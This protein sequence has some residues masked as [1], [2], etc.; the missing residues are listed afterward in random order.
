MEKLI[1]KVNLVGGGIVSILSAVLG[2]MWILFA[3]LYILNILDWITGWY[4][5]S[6]NKKS[7]SKVGAQ[8]IAKK[9][10]YWI[11]I[12][13]GFFI[14]YA[15][16]EMGRVIGIPLEFMKSIG[17]FVLANYIVN[18]MRSLLENLLKLGIPV[19]GFLIKGLRIT[20]DLIDNAAEGNLP[21]RKDKND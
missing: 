2:P 5:A 1:D 3:A 11:V 14:G 21:K 12:G 17:W 7:S 18:E 19:Q 8:G 16:K 10:G 20:S 6:K 15:F 4:W 13:V 9:V